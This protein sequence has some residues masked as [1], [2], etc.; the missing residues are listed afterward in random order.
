MCLPGS[1]GVVLGRRQDCLGEV[2]IHRWH[3][4][5]NQYAINSTKRH[6]PGADCQRSGGPALKAVGDLRFT[7]GILAGSLKADL[8]RARPRPVK[9][10]WLSRVLA[11]VLAAGENIIDH[12]TG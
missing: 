10:S 1:W 5:H 4:Y 6:R 9:A 3:A 11:L 7:S 2:Y 8:W 12:P